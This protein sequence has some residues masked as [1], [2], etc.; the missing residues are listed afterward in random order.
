MFYGSSE[1]I[2]TVLCEFALPCQAASHR[3][4]KCD[5]CNA[6]HKLHLLANEKKTGKHELDGFVIFAEFLFSFISADI[7]LYAAFK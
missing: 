6:V 1:D 4:E 2:L 5:H 3:K 7:L